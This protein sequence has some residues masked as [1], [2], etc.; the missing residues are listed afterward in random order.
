MDNRRKKRW[1]H[2]VLISL[3]TR[4]TYGGKINYMS[5]SFTADPVEDTVT[6]TS[7]TYYQG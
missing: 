2:P 4:K 1:K 7:G 5:E 3:D 6:H